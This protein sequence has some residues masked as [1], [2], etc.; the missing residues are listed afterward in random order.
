MAERVRFK[1]VL[2]V[3]EFRAMWL[4]ELC[5]IAGDQLARVALSVLVFQ[6]T[7][8]AFLTGLT[9]ALTF[10]PAL[11]GGILLGGLGDRYPRREVMVAADLAR[12]VLL[13]LMA[14][15]GMPLAVLCALVAVTTFLNGP[16]KAAQQA[17]LPDV[18]DGEKYTAGM[19]IRNITSQAAQL[20]GFAGGGALI[21]AINP[22][23]ALAL[24]A[25][26]FL[27]SALL[28]QRG[29]KQRP[30]PASTETR[31]SF[32]ASSAVGAQI[33]W[34][35]PALRVLLGLCWLAGFYV[36][37]E[38]LAAP[39]AGDMGPVA[40]GLIMASDPIGSVIGG[41]V[42][43]KWVPESTQVRVIGV[44]GVLAGVP[45]VFCLLAPGLAVSMLLFACSGL[46][47]TAYNIQ[48]TA[49]FVRRLPDERRAQGAGLLSSGL[50]TVQG[51]GALG[52]G[53]LADQL[54]PAPAVA[55]AG[56]A[57]AV[58]AVP[59]AVGWSRA[60]RG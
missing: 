35:D 11:A 31:M 46:F 10:V 4:A 42:F 54:G 53:L 29:V 49:S 9:Y 59:I 21:A 8:S 24:D 19:A 52:A 7:E 32:W 28:L 56:A 22:P 43:G 60:R 17:L 38:A 55:L 57:G 39:Y 48:G 25:G 5:S 50:I 12:A 27:A 51:L 23:V 47:A 18:L 1:N 40:V 15:P 33:V 45:L 2:A 26:T 13:G 44:L 41:I 58:V 36:V 37:P 34:R 16:F 30:A 3:R 6:R 14:L 20:A